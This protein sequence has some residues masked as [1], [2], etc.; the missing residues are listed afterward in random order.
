MALYDTDAAF[1]RCSRMWRKLGGLLEKHAY[2]AAEKGYCEMALKS[3]RIAEV[4]FWQATG[5]EDCV[6]MKDVAALPTKDGEA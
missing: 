3:A 2:A 5:E 6:R 1:G 4:C